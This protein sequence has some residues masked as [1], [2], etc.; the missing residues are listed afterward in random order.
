MIQLMKGKMTY[1]CFQKNRTHN[2]LTE[3]LKDSLNKLDS[4]LGNS[5]SKLSKSIDKK[6]D[7]LNSAHT[8]GQ[9]E[10]LNRERQETDTPSSDPTGKRRVGPAKLPH[11]KNKKRIISQDNDSLSLFAHSDVKVEL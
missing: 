1:E 10:D 3:A 8:S 7:K 6:I 4:A 9:P 11:N 5:V 2:V